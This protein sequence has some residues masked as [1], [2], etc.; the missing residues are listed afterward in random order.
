MPNMFNT[1]PR[2]E[3]EKVHHI[4]RAV[5]QEKEKAIIDACFRQ[6]RDPANV[7][8]GFDDVNAKDRVV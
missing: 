3:L 8:L 7:L 5:Y 2:A 4:P 6:E 1:Y